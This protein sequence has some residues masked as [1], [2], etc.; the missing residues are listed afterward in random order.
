MI[1][2][3]NVTKKYGSIIAL[4]DV[5]FHVEKG[6]IIGLLGPN[7]A[8]KTT[9][10]KVLTGYIQP[11]EGTAVIDGL[12]ILTHSM[13]VNSCISELVRRGL[14]KI[15]RFNGGQEKNRL[16]AGKRAALS[17]DVR[18]GLSSDDG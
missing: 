18:A 12:D 6:N 10:M 13:E 2:V 14:V 3:I 15:N 8:G 16:P 9:L 4:R 5:T 17:G 11:T 1:D 7:G